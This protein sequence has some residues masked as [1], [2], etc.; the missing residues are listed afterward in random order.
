MR[1]FRRPICL[2]AVMLLFPALCLSAMAQKRP[3]TE[4]DLFDFQWIGDTQIS[5]DGATIAF[6]KT[7]VA[8]DREGYETRI[9]LLDLKTPG[10]EPKLFADGPRDAAPRWSPDGK[11]IAFVRSAEKDGKFGPPQLYLKPL[12][13]GVT[14]VRLTEMPKGVGN[15]AWSPKGDAIAVV[16]ST[17]Q[18][19]DKAKLEAAKKARATGEDAHLS[20]VRIVTREVYRFN[21]EGNLDPSMVPQLYLVSLP[22]SDGTQ[23]PAWQM[24]GGRFGVEEYLWAKGTKGS[25][26]PDWIFYSSVHEEEP[27]YDAEGHNSIYGFEAKKGKGLAE[28]AFTDDLKI[29]ARGLAISHDGKR[30]AFHAQRRTEKPMSHKQTDLW[31]MDL[32]WAQGRPVSGGEPK[33]L[34]AK[35][36]YEMGG[37]VGGDNT[38]PR[39]GGRVGIAW[40]GDDTAL[41]DVV[42]KDGSALLVRVDATSGDVV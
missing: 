17:P 34:T 35:L 12:V 24:T 20:D 19:P 7:T 2:F 4:K 16:S 6:V 36:S 10:A 23:E 3:I 22:K 25:G 38:A 8:K 28:T 14:A 30:V 21:G 32:T 18:D 31:V 9:Y 39:G 1:A 11:Q 37:S 33:N 5:P 26:G 40:N 41:E 15:P 29:E 27:Y 13:A 42:A